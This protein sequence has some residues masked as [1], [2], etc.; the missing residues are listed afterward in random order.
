MFKDWREY[1]DHLLD[2][3]IQ[4]DVFK[5]K[6]Q[7]KHDQMDLKFSDMDR[8]EEMYKTQILGILSNDFE[9][10][11]IGNFMGRPEAINFLK[12][13]RGLEINWNRPDRDLRYIKPE[14]RGKLSEH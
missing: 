9:F 2:N 4:D 11:K 8:M 12:F 5:S 1:R 7:K 10:T 13:K 14:Q 3:L 6:I